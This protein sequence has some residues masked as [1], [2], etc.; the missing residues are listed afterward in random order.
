M[1]FI[2]IIGNFDS[3]TFCVFSPVAKVNIIGECKFPEMHESK[4]TSEEQC[5]E[6]EIVMF[7]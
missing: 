6:K 7:R 4:K 5:S 2:L 3:Q 1:E